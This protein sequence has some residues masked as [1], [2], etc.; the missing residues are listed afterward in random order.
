MHIHWV[1]SSRKSSPLDSPLNINRLARGR[2]MHIGIMILT[3]VGFFVADKK[4]KRFIVHI[5]CWNGT[6]IWHVHLIR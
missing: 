2:Q 6:V 3:R 5:K 4:K 1:Q